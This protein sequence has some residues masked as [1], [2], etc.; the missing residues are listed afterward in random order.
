MRPLTSVLVLALAL[1]GCSSVQVPTG[2]D[3]SVL[4]SLR[5]ENMRLRDRNRT[6]RDSLQFRDDLASGQYYRDLRTL[7]DRLARLTYEVRLLRSGGITVAVL[8]TDSLFATAADS[9]SAAGVERLRALARQ[10]Q[11][12]YPDR[13][14]RVEG[15]A[16]N[17]P[18]GPSLRDRYASN[19]ALS[20]VRATTVLRRLLALTTLDR[21]QFVAVGYGASQPRASNETAAGRRR[22][23]RVRV[24]VLPL[25]QNYSWPFE[26][27]W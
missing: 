20:S 8:P 22:N 19:W 3:A 23:R 7:R 26:G 18:V 15:H 11:S 25:P 4:D 27:S 13:T 21:G 1:I 14:V 24:S 6:L 5:A 16:D 12:T 9:L 17:T 2:D 10:L